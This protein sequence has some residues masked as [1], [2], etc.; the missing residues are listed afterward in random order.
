MFISNRKRNLNL[1][2]AFLLLP[3]ILFASVTRPFNLEQTMDTSYTVIRAIT[4]T[5]DNTVM[6]HS[7]RDAYVIFYQQ[8]GTTYT[9]DYTYTSN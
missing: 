2:V 4:T 6:A 5:D 8:S 1:F 3:S 9:E 7:N